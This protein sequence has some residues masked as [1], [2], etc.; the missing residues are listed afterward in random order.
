MP[1]P[2]LK[3]TELSDAELSQFAASGE[4]M[5]LTDQEQ[6]TLVARRQ[7]CASLGR[8][9]GISLLRLNGLN[10]SNTSLPEHVRLWECFFDIFELTRTSGFA[11]STLWQFHRR[12]SSLS[13]RN[14]GWQSSSIT[15]LW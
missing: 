10:A 14:R 13:C 8:E 15:S 5:L 4:A 6:R 9:V 2:E 7:Q 11:T 3:A 12:R 1:V